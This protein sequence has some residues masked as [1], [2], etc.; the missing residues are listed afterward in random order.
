MTKRLSKDDWLVFAFRELAREG[1]QGLSASRMAARLQVSR[2]SFYWHFD[3]V[4]NFETAVLERWQQQA[5]ANII[6]EMESIAAP[7][8][9][10]AR[11][12]RS[13]MS[14]KATLERAIR[15]WS[16][17]SARVAEFVAAVDQQ[18]IAYVESLLRALGARSRDSKLRA[19]LLYWASLGRM[20]APASGQGVKQGYAG[21]LDEKK[22]I[23]LCTAQAAP[24]HRS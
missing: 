11:L 20:M 1:H 10:L 8:E 16:Y 18:R 19:Q 13:S 3:N 9:R 23:E 17:D 5:T 24:G 7:R 6:G 22:L 2:G 15:C 21:A 12:I 14:A 4:E